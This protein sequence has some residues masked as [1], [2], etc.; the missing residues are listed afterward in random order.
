MTTPILT[1]DNLFRTFSLPEG[2]FGKPATL[3]AVSGVSLQV[4]PQ[5]AIGIA[6]E[7][8]CGK[9]TLA[10]MLTGLLSPTS[11][12]ISYAG[13]TLTRMSPAE[14]LAFRRAV[15]MV[16]QDPYSS[17]NPRQR[18]GQII[19]EPLQIHKLV[20]SS[21]IPQEVLRLLDAV[22]L[23]AEAAQRYPHEFSGG[24]RQRIGIARALAVNPQVLI[25]DE[26]VSALDLSIQAQ[27]INLLQE[28]R[29]RYALALVLIAHDLSVI[30]HLC[31]TVA[32][33]Y[34]GE[35]VEFGPCADIFT[36][37]RHPYTQALL[38]SIPQL[39]RPAG[40]PRT[41]LHGDL[42]S[43]VN[44]PPGCRFHTRCP[45]AADLCRQSAPVLAP[46]APNHLT[47]CHFSAEIFGN[48]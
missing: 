37:T 5:T 18:V 30:R 36:Q 32:I 19:A 9:S 33:M 11:G 14:M 24:Q 25:A 43:P 40:Q 6:G 26:P 2:A 41:V 4:W 17:L 12:S 7:S 8:G 3:T 35:I 38:A 39:D 20:T 47:A 10:K 28:L 31:D 44:P 34:L 13:K 21:A 27:I 23:P 48:Q 16:F 29:Q 1:A 22:G 46:I 15:Q 42:P 45:Y